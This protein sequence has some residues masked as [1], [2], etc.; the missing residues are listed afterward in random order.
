MGDISEILSQNKTSKRNCVCSYGTAW[1][2][3]MLY[4]YIHTFELGE[5]LAFFAFAGEVVS[6]DAV[7][8]AHSEC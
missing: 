8:S 7:T 3:H 6:L 1:A 4:T 2:K 5:K